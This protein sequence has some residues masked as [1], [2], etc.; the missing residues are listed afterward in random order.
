M[1]AR[2]HPDPSRIVVRDWIAIFFGVYLTVIV[3]RAVV[4]VQSFAT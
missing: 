3:P 4:V 2:S 1:G